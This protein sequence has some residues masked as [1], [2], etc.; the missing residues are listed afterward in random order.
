[1]NDQDFVRNF[2]TDST[3]LL[4]PAIWA[5]FKIG[6]I[7]R[8]P[9]K[10]FFIFENFTDWPLNGTQTTQIGHGK[11]K[12]FASAGSSVVPVHTIFGVRQGGG[13]LALNIGGNNQAACVAQ[14]YPQCMMTGYIDD[15]STSL[16]SLGPLYFEACVAVSTTASDTI[17][18]FVGLGET[19]LFTL[20]ALQPFNAA[21]SALSAN[22][23]LIGFLRDEDG[24]QQI[25]T[26]YS[27]RA[28]AFTTIGNH[29]NT[30]TAQQFVK[31]GFVYDPRR[32]DAIRFFINNQETTT[33]LTLT[34][35][36][37]TTN[38]RANA[39]GVLFAAIGDTS[40][41]GTSAVMRWFCLGQYFGLDT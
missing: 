26:V 6:S 31:L 33:P 32:S 8:R 35:L 41:A 36:R 20:S 11:Y 40:G 5:D 3:R 10:G 30:V 27:D 22:G 7:R 23:S 16:L 18:Y 37:A 24:G 21:S 9:D 38:L 19:D 15:V 29:A 17:G 2:Q 25:D 39:L 28:T 34:Q 14:A 12:L 13:A 1:M 4:S